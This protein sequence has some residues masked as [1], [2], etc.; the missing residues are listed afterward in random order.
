MNDGYENSPIFLHDGRRL[1]IECNCGYK[2]G[3][4]NLRYHD[5][6]DWMACPECGGV[7]SWLYEY[8]DPEGKELS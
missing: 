6:R 5:E 2:G 8:G 1:L 7:L 4:E 3:A